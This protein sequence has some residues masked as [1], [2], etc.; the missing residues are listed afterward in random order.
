M[1]LSTMAE[2]FGVMVLFDVRPLSYSRSQSGTRCAV[3]SLGGVHRTAARNFQ[4]ARR[5]PAQRDCGDGRLP[6]PRT[7]RTISK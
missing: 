3:C 6:C 1:D 2:Q 5:G 4:A 7:L